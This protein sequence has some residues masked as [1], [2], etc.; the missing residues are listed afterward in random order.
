VKETGTVWCW[1]HD[2][3]GQLGGRLATGSEDERELFSVVPVEVVGLSE[4]TTVVTS[5]DNSCALKRDATVWCW[6]HERYSHD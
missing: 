5:Y 4:A 2:E 1:G 3:Y 6:G